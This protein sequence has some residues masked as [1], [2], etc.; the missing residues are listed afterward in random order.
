MPNSLTTSGLTTATQAELQ[1]NFT[2]AL[3]TIYGANI[4]LASDTPDG[5]WM[6]IFIQAI[7]DIEDLLTEIYNSFDPDNAIGT[8][9]DQRVSMNGIQ[10]LAGTFTITNITITT[11]QSVNL[12]G[13]DQSTQPVYTVQDASG[14]Q[15]Q[16]ITTQ[17]A[18]STGANVL[19]FQAALP[20]SVISIPNTITIPV[21]VVLGVTAINNPTTYS[22]LG[23]NEESDAALKVRRASSVSL[24][25][26]GYLQGLLGALENINGITSVQ[27]F[28]ND[29]STTNSLGVPG[30]S[31]WAIV[32]GNATPATAPAWN[33]TTTYSYGQLVSSGSVNYISWQN[34]NTGNAVTNGTFWGLYNPVAQAIYQK[35]NAGCGMYGA[36]N[37]I[38]T[39]IDG[40]QFTVTYD[41]V[42][43]QTMFIKFTATSLDL[44]HAP[45]I[46]AI[47]QKLP[48]IFVPGVNTEVNINQLATYVQQIDPNT[49]VTSAGFSAT[50]TGT[51][52]STFSPTSPKYQLAVSSAD[53]IILT[54]ILSCPNGTPVINGSGVVTTTDISVVHGGHTIQFTG[55]GGYGTLTYS[56]VSGAGSINSSTGLYTSSTAGTDVAQVQDSLGNTATATITVS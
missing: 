50:S 21:T 33:S 1:T 16:L 49:L 53:I 14:N 10:R 56:M 24:S 45:N 4:D 41:S 18:L 15:W 46:A 40:S 6:N 54:M 25:S 43:A 31:L 48:Q 19:A 28:E 30:H 37:Y 36:T 23:V 5:Q 55:L 51:Y 27:V 11:N 12:Y 9:L 13:L 39:Q 26:Q 29:T 44:V 20:G 3:Q 32:A 17:L 47:I 22:V 42:S 52:T 8:Q 34:N 7:L 38:I 35:R 2:T